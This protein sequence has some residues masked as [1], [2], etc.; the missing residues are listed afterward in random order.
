MEGKQLSYGYAVLAQLVSDHHRVIITT[1]FDSLA[2]DALFQFGRQ[3]PFICGHERLVD[4]IPEHSTRPLVIKIHHDLLIAPVSSATGTSRLDG[5]WHDPI[6]RL[7]QRHIPIFIG[8]GGND[9]SLMNF[10]AELPKDTP[11]RLCKK[12]A[13]WSFWSCTIGGMGWKAWDAEPRTV[14]E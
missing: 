9:G 12:S 1:N 7:L 14:S 8:Y 2:S 4:Y 5:A 10:L 6:R 3:A 13:L 11:E